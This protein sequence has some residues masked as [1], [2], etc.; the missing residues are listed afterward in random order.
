MLE[1]LPEEDQR[2]F[3]L[4]TFCIAAIRSQPASELQEKLVDVFA[5]AA[6]D[7][8]KVAQVLATLRTFSEPA[9]VKPYEVRILDKGCKATQA[10]AEKLEPLL[11]GEAEVTQ[12]SL[13]RKILDEP[14]PTPPRSW[15]WTFQGAHGY[16][17]DAKL[18]R[19]S[20]KE[21][22]L[23]QPKTCPIIATFNFKGGVGKTTT[24]LSATA[25]LA[26]L[27]Y[28][29]GLVDADVQGNA[30]GFLLGMRE[31]ADKSESTQQPAP[32]GDA[33]LAEA[34]PRADGVICFT[35]YECPSKESVE[36]REKI[37]V[38]GEGT[39]E[40][41]DYLHDKLALGIAKDL[42]WEQAYEENYPNFDHVFY[43][44]KELNFEGSMPIF[45]LCGSAKLA[46]VEEDVVRELNK[47]PGETKHMAHVYGAFRV[48]CKRLAA[49]NN[50]DA[51]VVDVGPTSGLFNNWIVTSCDYVL[52]P[53]F[54]DKYSAQSIQDLVKDS[55]SGVLH[56]FRSYQ[57][58]WTGYCHEFEDKLFVRDRQKLYLPNPL[59]RMLPVL[60]SNITINNKDRL[61]THSF[62][63]WIYAIGEYLDKRFKQEDKSTEWYMQIPILIKDYDGAPKEVYH[64]NFIC[65]LA[66]ELPQAQKFC[67]PLPLLPKTCVS[68]HDTGGKRLNTVK[69]RY[70][71]LAQF[72]MQAMHM[73]E[74]PHRMPSYLELDENKGKNAQAPIER[75]QPDDAPK[76]LE[77]LY[78]FCSSVGEKMRLENFDSTDE[79][80]IT[81]WMHGEAP[82][83]RL[84]E[85][86]HKVFPA[87][88]VS[89]ERPSTKTSKVKPDFVLENVSLDS[90]L[91]IEV[92]RETEQIFHRPYNMQNH[93]DQVRFQMSEF[94]ARHA[95]LLNFKR[96][97][98]TNIELLYA[99]LNDGDSYDRAYDRDCW[100]EY[101]PRGQE[102]LSHSAGKRKRDR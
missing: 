80:V 15:L 21:L 82:E 32:D 31:S 24:A 1:P 2:R 83:L 35:E 30:T 55:K 10:F 69:G 33:P 38:L 72:L 48:L 47:K 65:S 58:E 73:P 62:A 26:K 41:V 64:W 51:I 100:R 49:H 37:P 25:A 29:V 54:A 14:Y 53:S 88:L 57:K 39:S 59:T 18:G 71:Q 102:R 63:S 9:A 5:Q 66:S 94:D 7:D 89:N 77:H 42:G 78:T 96:G 86:L 52:P 74:P 84:Q 93:F 8:D 44:M 67:T 13:L 45:L 79:P 50:L 6:N 61:V 101:L 68:R 36:R 75:L 12:G 85:Y 91:V 23:V 60:I 40:H 34:Q 17:K 11:D 92:K 81:A 3:I 27:G 90:G 4:S 46:G 56:R 19:S 95:V 98:G 70:K 22:T 43:N 99:K 28:K 16:G 20:N 87:A 97:G 76:V